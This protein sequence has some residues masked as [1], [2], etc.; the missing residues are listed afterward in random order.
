MSLEKIINLNFQRPSTYIHANDKPHLYGDLLTCDF[1][2][3]AKSIV[4]GNEFDLDNEK[5]K[6]LLA[7]G[8]LGDDGMF[9]FTHFGKTKLFYASI[10][11]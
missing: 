5:Y 6:V 10:I 11:N 8:Q 1:E 2:R 3:D 4:K 7:I 9:N